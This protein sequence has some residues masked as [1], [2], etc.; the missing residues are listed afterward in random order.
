MRA[1]VQ[2]RVGQRDHWCISIN[3]VQI[4][5][6]YRL[7]TDIEI[8]FGASG[9]YEQD[10]FEDIQANILWIHPACSNDSF[11]RDPI[12]PGQWKCWTV[13]PP[14]SSKSMI[15]R[16]GSRIKHING[17]DSIST[18]VLAEYEIPNRSTVAC[19][20]KPIAG[21]LC[22]VWLLRSAGD[23]GPGS[24]W[25]IVSGGKDCNW[26]HSLFLLVGIEKTVQRESSY[27]VGFLAVGVFLY[28][29]LS[30][31]LSLEERKKESTWT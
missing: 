9:D 16:P 13:L 27:R 28:L 22:L 20:Q 23:P 12:L 10:Q 14:P 26:I 5:I 29:S 17:W 8:L 1:S 7:N 31:T 24:T 25:N 6:R 2:D 4:H 19:R 30:A 3:T 15:L 11:Y 21:S 18:L